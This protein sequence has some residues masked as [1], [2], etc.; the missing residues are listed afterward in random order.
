MSSA[1]LWL[2]LWPYMNK[3]NGK[4]TKKL[5]SHLQCKVMGDFINLLIYF[6]LISWDIYLFTTDYFC[7]ALL[8]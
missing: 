1:V 5:S 4:I 3:N 2:L 6:T 7:D 8:V